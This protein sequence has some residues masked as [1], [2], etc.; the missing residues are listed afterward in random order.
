VEKQ[1]KKEYKELKKCVVPT[2]GEDGDK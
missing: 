1:N 2:G